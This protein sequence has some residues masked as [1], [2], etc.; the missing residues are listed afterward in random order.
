[1]SWRR[2]ARLVLPLGVGVM[3]AGCA[4]SQ[5]LID[6]LE[7]NYQGYEE[8]SPKLSPR[9]AGAAFPYTPGTIL[10]VA[11]AA[12]E[13][14]QRTWVAATDLHCSPGVALSSLRYWQRR[15]YRM[16]T[17]RRTG[18]A[19]RTWLEARLGGDAASLGGVSEVIVDV[20]A[21]RSYEPSARV[22]ADL[23]TRAASGCWLPSGLGG[24]SVRRVRGV[25]VGDVRVRLYFEQGVDLIARSQLSEQLSVALGFGFARISESE[26]AG[27]NVAFGIKWQ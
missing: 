8:L 18:S 10:S 26:I 9:G 1:M 24:G 12:G 21:V 22:L 20:R 16:R 4:P 13:R 17:G 23:N 2:F 3:A 15:G 19:A 27:R 6:A 11:A 5:G 14:E 7:R 25:I